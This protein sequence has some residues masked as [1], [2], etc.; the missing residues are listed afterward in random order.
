MTMKTFQAKIRFSRRA[1]V[2]CA[3]AT[4]LIR[5]VAGQSTTS[6]S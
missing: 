3:L 2:W 5:P 1:M 6:E 4:A